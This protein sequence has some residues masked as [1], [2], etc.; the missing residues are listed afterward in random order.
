MAQEK[1]I[2]DPARSKMATSDSIGLIA[3]MD[4]DDRRK[5][6]TTSIARQISM[7]N[8]LTQRKKQKEVK[9]EKVVTL[10]EDQKMNSYLDKIHREHYSVEQWQKNHKK[11]Q[12]MNN[13]VESLEMRERVDREQAEN[14]L[15]KEARIN[16]LYQAQR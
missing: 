13:I 7:E 15:N 12:L 9:N 4:G 5:E 8:N 11:Q 6:G 16:K 2:R 3:L 14:L 1:R 10:K